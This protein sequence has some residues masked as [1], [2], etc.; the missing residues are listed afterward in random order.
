MA[1][2][3]HKSELSKN[4]RFSM[5]K[6]GILLSLLLTVVSIFAQ[7]P[8]GYLVTWGT[9]VSGPHGGTFSKIA[10]GQNHSLAI[11]P[12]S[13]L[14]AWGFN[15]YGQCNVPTGSNFVA[16][17]AGYNYSLALRSNGTVVA[18]GFNGYNQ[19]NVPPDST[20]VAI[21]AGCYH[22]LALKSDGT[23]L[24]W[25]SNNVG[26][27]N[28]PTG[29]DFADIS[30]GCIHNVALKSDSTLV[31]WGCNNDGECSVPQIDDFIAIAAG[32]KVSAAIV[33][34]EPT[35]TTEE[36]NNQLSPA[37]VRAYPNPAR[38]SEGVSF[39][40]KL[41]AHETG[42]LT[43]YNLKGQ[44]VRSFTVNPAQPKLVWNGTDEH[45]TACAAGIYLYRLSTN[46]H[47]ETR[48]LM[49]VK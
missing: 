49:I 21:A 16:V 43:I 33:G 11:K 8:S 39:E 48:K 7:T 22:S 6:A 1:E 42:S 18:W 45:N 27:C 32:Y 4:R 44:K 3:S 37:I 2:A 29:N 31:A 15:Y 5:K 34:V 28:V 23:L 9:I 25:G 41:K 35:H 14:S 40:T 30:T 13:T 26:Q 24:A 19:C 36:N 10:V 20:I 17:A 46:Y 38:L 47:Q 12:D